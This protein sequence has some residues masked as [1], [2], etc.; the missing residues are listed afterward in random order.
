MM[1]SRKMQARDQQSRESHSEDSSGDIHADVAPS[2][3]VSRKQM[4]GYF[5]VL[6]DALAA[7]QVSDRDGHSFG[8]EVAASLV[9]AWAREAHA[10]GRKLIFIGNGGS[11]AIASHMAVD[12]SK[13]GGLR[14]VCLNDG[15]ML[16]CLG[17]DLG[18]EQVFAR[19]IDLFA[20]PGDLLI[21]I[22]SS[23][24]SPNI[25]NAVAVAEQRGC[26]IVTLSGFAP[27]NPL[28]SQGDI[29]FYLASDQYGF[30]EIGHLTL[31]HAI[32]DF[33]CGQRVPL[34][35]AG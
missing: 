35:A 12:Y 22:S 21:A 11:A 25:L 3:L 26:R 18:Y 6:R 16:T 19:Q 31:C 7:T 20:Q 4:L 34:P 29:N 5:D 15:A 24:R 9:I 32:L 33:A 13:N 14:A 2:P 8:Q 23:G 27:D 30:V 10:E 17:N 1:K 28:R